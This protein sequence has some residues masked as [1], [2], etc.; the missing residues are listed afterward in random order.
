MG[1]EAPPSWVRPRPL[2]C[3]AL[4]A[5]VAHVALQLPGRL[6]LGEDGRCRV[7]QFGQQMGYR[8]IG[9]MDSLLN[10]CQ[11]ARFP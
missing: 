7:L 6:A 3:R 1:D 8:A 10:G 5:V 2:K 4:G 9:Q 11:L